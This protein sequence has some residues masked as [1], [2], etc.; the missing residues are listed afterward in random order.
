MVAINSLTMLVLYGVLGGFLL[1]VGKLPIPW[2]ALL[3]SVGIYVTLPLGGG[4]FFQNLDDQ[5]QRGI[6]V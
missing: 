1:G 5:G 6:M 3:L 2:Q 4:L